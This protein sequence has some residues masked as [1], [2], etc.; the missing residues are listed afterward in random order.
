MKTE[1]KQADLLNYDG[2]NPFIKTAKEEYIDLFLQKAPS[3][4]IEDFESLMSHKVKTIV[5]SP[6]D[7]S[8]L[9]EHPKLNLEHSISQLTLIS[10]K[11]M[12]NI[13]LIFYRTLNIRVIRL[14][15]R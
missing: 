2:Q 15:N 13:M 9:I 3:F 11:Y 14:N 5:C 12:I 4:K 8:N 7:F 1:F 6:Y 10:Q